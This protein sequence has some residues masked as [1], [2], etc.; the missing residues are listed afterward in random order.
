MK[1]YRS[2][3]R[4]NLSRHYLPYYDTLCYLLPECWQPV[5][6][7]R[8]VEEQAAI[9]AQGRTIPGRI[10][11]KAKPLLSF[12]NY[13]LATDWGYFEGNKYI[14]TLRADDPTW[15]EY[16]DACEKAGL[17]CISWERP[18]N[19]L[20]IPVRIQALKQQYD[21]GG[22]DKVDDYLERILHGNRT[23]DS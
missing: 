19:Q 17:Q 1:N 2:I 14:N 16:V 20:V 18:H 5:S 15:R 11:T 8:T 22:L 9:Y 21:E 6:G 10:V 23:L 12:H 3:Y 7:F 13:G 4:E